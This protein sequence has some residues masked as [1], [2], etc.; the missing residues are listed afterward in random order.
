MPLTHYVNFDGGCGDNGSGSSDIKRD[1][2]YLKSSP[3]NV[4]SI[5]YLS[6]KCYIGHALFHVLLM[7][8]LQRELRE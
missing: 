3:T 4:D 8:L 7:I 5:F 1:I 6:K 2:Q